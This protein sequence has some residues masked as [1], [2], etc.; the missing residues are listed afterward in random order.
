MKEYLKVRQQI[1]DLL[2]KIKTEFPDLYDTISEMA[3]VQTDL[4]ADNTLNTAQLEKY[5]HS[6]ENMYNSY[7]LSYE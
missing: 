6:L 2:E 3:I 4:E 5:L 1:L 7:K